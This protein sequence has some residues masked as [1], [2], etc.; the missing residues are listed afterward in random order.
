MIYN[1]L[2]P[3]IVDL[4]TSGNTVF[5][6]CSKTGFYFDVLQNK[7]GLSIEKIDFQRSPYDIRNVNAYKKLLKLVKKEKID[8]IFCHEPVGGAM[9]RIVG[10]KCRCKV[11]YMAHGFHF[12]KGAPKKSM[13]YYAVEK[14]LSKYTD[15]LIT[16]NQE[17]YDAAQGFFARN[18][19]KTNGIGIDT[20]K[21]VYS[22]DP[23]YLREELCLNDNSVVILS[24]G[25]LIKRK[26]HRVVIQAI[27]QLKNPLVHY[28]IAGDG[29]LESK[30][31]G[32]VDD[33]NLRQQVHFLG[34][35]TDINQLCNAADIFILPSFQEGLSVALMEAMACGKPV[36]VSRIRGNVDIVDE[37]KG[38]LLAD[39]YSIE[40]FKDAIVFMNENK[41]LQVKY[42]RYNL[43]K[44]K[45]YDLV[46]IR[47][48]MRSIIND[49]LKE[50]LE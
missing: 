32:L 18:V 2:V 7:H 43:E 45:N 4:E 5:C 19:Y 20:S 38:G 34:Y 22:P 8:I 15:A 26:N 30:L 36:I 49:Q 3:Y 35:R 1:F 37:E 41:D 47:A 42:G 17:D 23:H 25:E 39:P 31:K 16:I 9:G 6:A 14:W 48:Q 44:V 29:V 12:F 50:S 28:V 13:I 10:H 46:E 11:I 24:V 40:E 33:L 21:F 27:S